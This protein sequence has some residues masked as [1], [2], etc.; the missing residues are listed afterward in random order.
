MHYEEG[1]ACLAFVKHLPE[2]NQERAVY[3]E[4]AIEAF[5]HGGFANWTSMAQS[6]EH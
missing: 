6:L 1:M 2:G 3:L 5:T 4:R